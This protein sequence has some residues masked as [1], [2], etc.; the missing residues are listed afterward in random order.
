MYLIILISFLVVSNGV[1]LYKVI[2]EHVNNKKLRKIKSDAVS[3]NLD[4]ILA[5]Y[6][7]YRRLIADNQ[8]KFTELD[9]Y[10][11]SLDLSN[12]TKVSDGRELSIG[13]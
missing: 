9:S 3:Q 1:L 6:T 7:D 2:S 8:K 5:E 4:M 11:K 10:L 13:E 12:Y